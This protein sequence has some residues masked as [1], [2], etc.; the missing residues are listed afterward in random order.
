M[1]VTTALVPLR[2]SLGLAGAS[3]C[4]LV[5]VVMVGLPGGLRPALLATGVGVLSSDFPYTQP[6]CS[7]R[8]AHMVDVVGLITFAVAAAVGG[9]VGRLTR[10]G[11]QASAGYTSTGHVP[12]TLGHCGLDLAV[13]MFAPCFLGCPGTPRQHPVSEARHRYRQPHKM[14]GP[15]SHRHLTWRCRRYREKSRIRPGL[16][17]TA[18]VWHDLA[19]TAFRLGRR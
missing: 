7:F 18:A 16:S 17:A 8:V 1:L 2:S 3:L 11:V 4:A 12:G 19:V 6:L 14:A 13:S 9:L 15:G 5:A 10:Q